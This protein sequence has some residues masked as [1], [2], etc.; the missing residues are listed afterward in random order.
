[1]DAKELSVRTYPNPFNSSMS[2][3]CSI[4]IA[5]RVTLKV[6]SML[7]REIATLLDRDAEVGKVTAEFTAGRTLP[8]GLYLYRL[9]TE[10]G[11]LTGKITLMK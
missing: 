11:L 4:P 7:G 3:E 6:Y 1:M 9:Q 8:S 2:F 5:S 10:S